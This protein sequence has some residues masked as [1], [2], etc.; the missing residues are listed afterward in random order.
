MKVNISPPNGYPYV[1]FGT[2]DKLL[3][4]AATEQQL[5]TKYQI[6]KKTKVKPVNIT[7]LIK[8]HGHGIVNTMLKQFGAQWC[9]KY[10]HVFYKPEK[11][12]A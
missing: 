2:K 7:Q 11:E 8:K 3:G 9:T 6:H 12:V 5:Y 4:P 10:G 1:L